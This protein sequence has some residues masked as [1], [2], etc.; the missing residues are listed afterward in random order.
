MSS[1]NQDA[2][3]YAEDLIRTTARAFY[4]DSAICLIDILL[5]DRFL[6]DDDMS[7]RLNLSAKQLRKTLTFLKREHLVQNEAVDDLDEGGSQSTVFWYIDYNMAVHA[8]RLRMKLMQLKLKE[9]EDRAR[10]CSMYVCPGYE[11]G[12]CGGRY[13]ETEA[14]RVTDMESGLFLCR[15]CAR[16]HANNPNPPSKEEYTLQ[17]MDNAEDLR[18]AMENTRRVRVQMSGKHVGNRHL[19]RGIYDLIQTVRKVGG[20]QP[21]TS[22]LPSENREMG[23]GSERWEGTGRT[24][25]VRQKKKSQKA[26]ESSSNNNADFVDNETALKI[27]KIKNSNDDFTDLKNAMGQQLTFTLEKGGGARANL[28]ATRGQRGREILDAAAIRIGVEPDLVSELFKQQKRKKE[29]EEQREAAEAENGKKKPKYETL[30]F[31]K[32]N[33]GRNDKRDDT[34]GKDGGHNPQKQYVDDEDTDNDEIGIPVDSDDEFAN[35]TDDERRV[36]FSAYY[37]KELMRQKR[38]LQLNNMTAEESARLMREQQQRPGSGT[39]ANGMDGNGE[40]IAWED[41]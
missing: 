17:L 2:T 6:R 20:S 1:E 7:K 33:I 39:N 24:Y 8:I 9:A 4:D 41:G 16:V 26:N 22:N 40:L 23:I 11:K 38:L 19:R 14:L 29:E 13:T 5:Q 10:S 32:D 36:R 35:M 28:L 21:L 12:L 25:G 15:E 3:V 34:A 18:I 31:L 27:K 37:K 30:H